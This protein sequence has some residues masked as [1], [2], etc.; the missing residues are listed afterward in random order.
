M[1]LPLPSLW[2]FTWNM[3]FCIFTEDVLHYWL[4]RFLHIPKWYKLIHKVHHTFSAPFGFTASYAHPLEVLILGIP[5]FA[6]PMIIQCHYF[7]FFCWIIFR[8]LDAVG[9]H[10][11]YDLPHIFDLLPFF[12]GTLV[13]DFHHKNFIFNYSSRFTFMDK[14]FG[15]YKE[16][17]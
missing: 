10:S 15:T 5:T 13:H 11:G 14:W 6:G 2:T 8:Q 1:S 12:G 16:P 9:T 4:H 7:T 3:A 17:V